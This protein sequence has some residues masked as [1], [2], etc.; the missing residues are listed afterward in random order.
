MTTGRIEIVEVGARDGLQNES[1]MLSVDSKFLL[2]QKLA[3]AGLQRIEVGA[4]VSA[5][6]V[7]QMKDS[8]ELIER[9]K[10]DPILGK[11]AIF[12]KFSVLVPNAR[13]MEQAIASGMREVAVF[14]SCTESFSQK[15]IN[16]SIAESFERFAEVIAMAKK[17]KVRVRGYLSMAFGCPYEGKVPEARVVQLAQR[18]HKLGIFEISIGDTIGIAHPRQVHSLVKKLKQRIPIKK[19]ALHFHDT[20]GLALANIQEGLQSGVRVFDSSIG[21]LGGCPYA[22]GATGNVATEDVQYLLQSQG[23]RT[24]LKLSGLVTAAKF[25]ETEFG[26]HL[27]SKMARLDRI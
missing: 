27:S 3:H 19:I 15:N 1:Q 10:H 13:G 5:K 4:F 7:P 6:A 17:S 9:L 2:I 26:K 23:Y 16:C 24:G 20:R 25:L 18:M 11:P 12:N 8:A 22:R 21:G 14:G